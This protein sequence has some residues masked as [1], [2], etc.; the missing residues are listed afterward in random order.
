M[1]ITDFMDY[2]IEEHGFIG[3]V[4]VV[5]A[6]TF[7]LLIWIAISVMYVYPFFLPFIYVGWMFYKYY[8]SGAE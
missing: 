5:F 2:V 7:V 6:W 4:S 1:R 8:K 3:F